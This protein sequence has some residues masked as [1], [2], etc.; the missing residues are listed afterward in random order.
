MNRAT[1]L[2]P[3]FGMHDVFPGLL[4]A[5]DVVSAHP[6]LH[7]S[8]DNK[9]QILQHNIRWFYQTI[10][11]VMGGRIQVKL[12]VM[13]AAVFSALL[14]GGVPIAFAAQSDSPTVHGNSVSYVL[15]P[16]DAIKVAEAVKVPRT[17]SASQFS[18]AK[19]SPKTY[20]G[21]PIKPKPKV[22]YDG[23]A[24]KFGVDY[25]LSYSANKKAGLAKVT[26]IGKGVYNGSKT[27]GFKIKRATLSK[28]RVSKI[29]TRKYTGKAIKP[30]P[31]V[32][33]K[34]KKLERGRDY[35]LSYSSNRNPGVAK[36]KVK[37]LGNYTGS[38][39][40]SFKISKPAAKKKSSSG[41]GTVYWTPSGSVYHYSRYCSTLSRS[42]IINS[43]SISD[44]GK[45][46]AC[47]V[48]G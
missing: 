36:V 34:G 24:L 10:G 29:S 38:K 45:S 41:V 27:A 12:A 9:L 25:T 22:S 16:A 33:V 35:K 2:N 18:V 20:V 46:R 39:T 13:L 23:I 3:A 47:K 7:K 44:S 43:G 14:I 19:I 6:I 31:I 30:L 5:Q 40:V 17:V 32:R 21:K 28:A 8:F 11:V 15:P 42:R 1:A 4:R 48:C 37:G 26:I